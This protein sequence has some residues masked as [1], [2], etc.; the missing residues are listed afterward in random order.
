L[1]KITLCVAPNDVGNHHLH[2]QVNVEPAVT[3]LSFIVFS[4]SSDLV[5]AQGAVI[6]QAGIFGKTSEGWNFQEI[7][8][9]YE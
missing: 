4:S 8:L 7:V 3:V 9:Q 6:G 5:T 1:V 2:I